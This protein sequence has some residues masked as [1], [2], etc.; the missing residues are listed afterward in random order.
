M[1]RKF[2][3]FAGLVIFSTS[4]C[5]AGNLEDGFAVPPSAAKT[6]TWW[7]WMNGNVTKEGITTDLEAMA[8]GGL[9]G[10]QMFD[11]YQ[12]L[13]DE[14]PVKYLSPEWLEMARFSASEAKRLGLQLGFHNCSGWSSSGGPWVT[15]AQSMQILTTSRVLVKGPTVFDAV[16][17]QPA[18]NLGFYEDA[19]VVAYP[20]P[21]GV[22]S[23]RDA[24]PEITGS[25]PD[26]ETPPVLDGKPETMANLPV[27]KPGAP[28]FIDFTF[29]E[30]FTARAFSVDPG[31]SRQGY[32]GQLQVSDDGKI[33]RSVRSWDIQ[34]ARGA[35]SFAFPAVTGRYFRIL[36][37]KPDR[38]FYTSLSIAGVDLTSEVEVDDWEQKAGYQAY[39]KGS[40]PVQ[41]VDSA[42]PAERVIDLSSKLQPGG[43]LNWEV[44]EG[45]WAILRLGHTPIGGETNYNNPATSAGRGLEC[46]KLDA[47]AVKAFWAGGPAKIIEA[48]KPYVGTTVTDILIDSYERGQPNWTAKFPQEFEKRRGYSMVKYLPVLTGRVVGSVEES[49]R[50]LWDVRQTIGDLFAEN[51]AGTFARLARKNNLRFAL[52]GG[53]LVVDQMRYMGYADMPTSEIWVKWN[54]PLVALSASIAHVYGRSLVGDETMTAAPENERWTADPFSLKALGDGILCAGINRFLFHTFVHQPWPGRAPGLTMG[55]WGS[56]LDGTNTWWNQGTDWRVYLARCQYLLQQGTYVADALTFCGENMPTGK[57]SLAV[58]PGYHFDTCNADVLLNR[59]SV[60]DGR[61]TLPNG[62]SYAFLSLGDVREMTPP[63][64]QKI[65]QLVQDGATIVGDRPTKSPSLAGYPQ[66]D[67]EISKIA[68]ELW[69]PDEK[70]AGHVCGKGLVLSGMDASAV[71]KKLNL[72]PDFQSSA[73]DADVRFIHQRTASEEIYFVSNQKGAPV[74]IDAEFRVQGKVPELWNAETGVTES[75]P[76]YRE[77]SAGVKVPLSFPP[78]GS[79]F[80]IFRKPAKAPH[81]VSATDASLISMAGGHAELTAWKAG[82]YDFE[83]SDG[84]SFKIEVDKLPLPIAIDG[85]WQLSFPPKL[86]A[87]EKVTLEKLNSW[88]ENPDKGV[89]YFAGTA[90]YTKTF[91]LPADR[92]KKGQS[93]YLDLGEVKNLARVKVNGKDL[94]VVWKPPF[95][96]DITDA[97]KAGENALE[98]EVTNLWPNRLIGDEQLPPDCEWAADGGLKAFPAWLKEGKPSPT[99]RIAFTTWHHWKKDDALLPSGLLGPVHIVVAQTFTIP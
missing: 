15:P 53:A 64:L 81:F 13:G 72:P 17:P 8:R 52:E 95:R 94:G 26:F 11:V 30:P 47:D 27:P 91:N 90:T 80:V 20:L 93:L 84:K 23:L 85:P 98:I 1:S 49:E 51:Y 66:C 10:A 92:I 12:K 36:F 54:P 38:D 19:A 35:R 97:V 55:K 76:V 74:Q 67:E 50:F 48:L 56:H 78:S 31:V 82:R 28:Q 24:A 96:V 60:K 46:D 87:P 16:L 42:I 88:T 77:T 37:Q 43:R 3:A 73:T 63:V 99:G 25:G 68:A 44:P 18:T 71:I 33:Y 9:G 6:W 45:N 59:L 22:R 14:G 2:A 62:A 39:P 41:A 57:T 89:K 29:P 86:G 32:H 75:A 5:M 61:I 40:A 4:F 83:S 70:S 7:H 69:G 58:P 21:E 79:V 65:R 34:H